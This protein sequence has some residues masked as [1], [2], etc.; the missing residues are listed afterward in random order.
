MMF[1]LLRLNEPRAHMVVMATV[2]LSFGATLIFQAGRYYNTPSYGNLLQIMHPS[3]WGL[4]YLAAAALKIYCI[5]RPTDRTM[6]IVT[7]TVGIA[8]VSTWLLAF[9]V[10]YLTDDGTTIVNVASWSVFLYLVIRS[11]LMVDDHVS[12]GE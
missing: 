2:F 4:I 12:S 9:V 1:R 3:Y 7:H 5:V 6:I 11:A 8:L 10:R